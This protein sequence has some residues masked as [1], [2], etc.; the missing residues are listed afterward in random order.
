MLDSI[1]GNF[2]CAGLTTMK[3]IL[4]TSV[5]LG[6]LLLSTACHV[7]AD[8]GVPM[9]GLGQAFPQAPNQSL[10]PN[11]RVYV[12]QRDG[13]R[14]IQVNDVYGHVLG[15]FVTSQ[16]QWLALPIGSGATSVVSGHAQ[17]SLAA[18]GTLNTPVTSDTCDPEDC[19]IGHVQSVVYSQPADGQIN[20]IT[21]HD[22]RVALSAVAPSQCDPEDCSVGH[23]VSGPPH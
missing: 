14:F 1:V 21:R 8:P 22:G 4:S 11:W 6:T 16:G 9:T 18:S 12:F 2:A 10:N 19:S 15:A 17:R 20:V 13:L 7:Y 5:L 3:P 23:V